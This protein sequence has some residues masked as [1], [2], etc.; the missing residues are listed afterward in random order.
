MQCFSRDV[1]QEMV[2]RQEK[3]IQH[4]QLARSS[5]HH[6]HHPH[7]QHHHHHHH[8]HH[9][10]QHN[11]HHYQEDDGGISPID[12]TCKLARSS[13]HCHSGSTKPPCDTRPPS[14]SRPVPV[15]SGSPR[16][17]LRCSVPHALRLSCPARCYSACVTVPSTVL[18][19]LFQVGYD[20]VCRRP[21]DVPTG[22]SH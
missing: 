7:H 12:V 22:Q 18:L 15:R 10:Y 20:G 5:P 11:N 9:H 13:D 4:S 14:D 19:S 16:I 3:Q 1:F 2:E 8:H 17:T 21:A 6:P